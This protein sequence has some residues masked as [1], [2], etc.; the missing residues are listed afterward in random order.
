MTSDSPRPTTAPAAE[1][2]GRDLTLDLV[3]VSCVVLVVF[4]HILFSGV[5]RR[6]D[7][8]ILIERTVEAQSWFD[9]VSWIAD[10]MPLFFV[11]GGF[12][13][14]AGWRSAQRR[15]Q[16]A[17]DFAR[18]RLA[19]L[20]RPALPLFVFFALALAGARMLGVD[21]ALVDTVSIGVGSPL[22]FLAAYMLTQALAPWMI[23]LHHRHGWR[24]LVVLL[25]GALVVDL[26]RFV[27]V[28]DVL[29]MP[30]LPP[31]RYG[32][33]EE[34]FGLPNVLFVWLFCQQIGFFLFDGWFRRLSAAKL[35][36]LMSGG[37]GVAVA[38]VPLIGYSWNMLA[39]Q[40]PP[41]VPMALMAVVQA[42]G[43]TLVHRPLTAL[44]RSRAVQ[45][46]IFVIGSRLMT[47]YLWHLPMIMV[48]TGI[49]LLLPLPMP[50][51]G[52]ALWWWTRVPFLLIVLA[53]VWLLSLALARFE[54]VPRLGPD[55]FAAAGTM[56]VLLFVGAPLA[57]TAY[58][59]D[60]PLAALG[61]A[62]TSAALWLIGGFARRR[63][64]ESPAAR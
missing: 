25:S 15:G 2:T 53:A 14:R 45:A 11:V 29:G 31:D 48:L 28:R 50:H 21:A 43:L 42:A 64:P 3:R 62:G 41:T 52:S 63:M 23:A 32:A 26:V 46:I 18:V 39:N 38:M 33:G 55:P 47:V 40:W 49:Q 24:V 27:G 59:L 4:A 44:T 12:A 13:A 51:P 10:I 5:G 60:L 34:L 30:S 16:G 8:S 56:G 22:W 9:V 1:P 54:R 19:R 36:A 7:G 17:S 61:V 6:D 35:L 58:G 37:A 57:V 20:A